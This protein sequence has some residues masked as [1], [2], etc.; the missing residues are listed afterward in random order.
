MRASCVLLRATGRHCGRQ[1]NSIAGS[2]DPE[3]VVR[4]L[5]T[6]DFAGAIHLFSRLPTSSRTSALHEALILAC[7][8]IPDAPA[9]H[10]VLKAMPQ[11]SLA[12]YSHVI[13]AHCR[14]RNP[15]AAI[16]LLEA[17][18]PGLGFNLDR[19]VLNVISR[20]IRKDSFRSKAQTGRESSSHDAMI[21][22]KRLDRL[23]LSCP[24]AAADG[25]SAA[26]SLS[27]A[28]FFENDGGDVKEWLALRS[29][30]SSGRSENGTKQTNSTFH[31]LSSIVGALEGY[32]EPMSMLNRSP[33]DAQCTDR[34]EILRRPQTE[35]GDSKQHAAEAELQKARGDL[36]RVEI[37]TK[38]I[39]KDPV[40]FGDIATLS[41][42]VSAYISCGPMGASRGLDLLTALF[43]GR[44]GTL[45]RVV[46]ELQ[47]SPTNRS[48]L[49]TTC[50]SAVAASASIAPIQ[51]LEAYRSLVALPVRGYKNSLPLSGA[52]LMA[53]RHAQHPLSDTLSLISEVRENVIQFDEQSF[54][55]ALSAIL[56][57]SGSE[58]ERWTKARAWLST[59]N[60]AGI[61]L[62]IYTY[63]IF[64]AQLRY[65][66]NPELA[67]SLLH[68]MTVGGVEPSARTYGLIFNSFVNRR[69][70]RQEWSGSQ[71][72]TKLRVRA[73]TAIGEHMAYSGVVHSSYSRLALARAYA[74][75]GEVSSAFEHF[76]AFEEIARESPL[77][78]RED[79]PQ[80]VDKL[81]ANFSSASCHQTSSLQALN[82]YNQMLHS[83]A[84]SRCVSA[85]SPTAVFSMYERMKKARVP[86]DAFTLEY[87]LSA[88]VRVGQTQRAI[89]YVKEI[90][91]IQTDDKDL[92]ALRPQGIAHLFSVLANVSTPEAWGACE[93][94][95]GRS[96]STRNRFIWSAAEGPD[97]ITV[98]AV[99]LAVL[100]FARRGYVDICTRI[101]DIT[102]VEPLQW[103]LSLNGEDFRRVRAVKKGRRGYEKESTDREQ[104]DGSDCNGARSPLENEPRSRNG[105]P[106][107]RP[108]GRTMLTTPQSKV[109]NSTAMSDDP[110]IP[111]NSGSMSPATMT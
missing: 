52:V 13:S 101:I 80:R 16:D 28:D 38:K 83:F 77:D 35:A 10:A 54:S 92:L 55:L 109:R 37:A 82:A 67:T 3:S 69:A 106:D 96:L 100:A 24:G 110:A 26:I 95:L 81:K 48:L 65:F 94:V 41:A 93:D 29:T 18:P 45:E 31:G 107:R 49:L 66:S 59:M 12:A 23:A 39:S 102:G 79:S 88:C 61:P 75:L 44:L 97:A 14:E 33:L 11:P 53:L 34:G 99:E 73:L 36:A 17:M 70:F 108:T 86:P 104:S 68:E 78:F 19:R 8:H 5:R 20:H 22:L 103:Q 91:L 60:T 58:S 74:H 63:N 9:A 25:K 85:D 105:I 27:T 50:T 56:N 90:A 4:K 42:A 111:N 62:T 64:A 84:H 15:A 72:S 21:L 32:S 98:G 6:G 71:H 43:D 30:S 46:S 2:G 76:V 7:A 47:R 40:L 89:E 87:L 51:A 1:P 57:S